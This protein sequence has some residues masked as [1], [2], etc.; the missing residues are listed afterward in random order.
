MRTIGPFSPQRRTLTRLAM[1]ALLVVPLAGASPARP[2]KKDVDRA[3]AAGGA[4]TP[5]G[6]RKAPP[7]RPVT[8]TAKAKRFYQAAWG[9]DRLKVSRVASGTLIRFTYRVTD[10][11]QAAPLM[12][13]GASPSLYAARARATLAVPIMEKIGP[14]RQAGALKAGK[15]YWIA[16]SNKGNLVRSGDRVDVIVGRFRADG[17]IVE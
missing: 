16:F 4:T 11:S 1:A 7:H 14:L 12:E 5:H 2:A 3:V 15:E 8:T 6:A 17:L 10:P 9:V 13:K